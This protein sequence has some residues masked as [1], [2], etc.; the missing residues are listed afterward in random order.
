METIEV[1]FV[2]VHNSARSQMAEAYFNR[3]AS[4]PWHAQSAGIEPGELNPL[5]VQ[6]MEEDGIDI[7]GNSTK[8]VFDIYEKGALFRY[9]VTV[10]DRSAAQRCP[11]FPGV[12]ERVHW[13]FADPSQF[14]GSKDER[15]EQTRRVRDQIRETVLSWIEKLKEEEKCLP[16][17]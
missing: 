9:V 8:S 3:F 17:D 15:L 1:L 4:G 11:V 16:S 5:V 14:T 7:S 12:A 13:G 6:V 10:C 2:C